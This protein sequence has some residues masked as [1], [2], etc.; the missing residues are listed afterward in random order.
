MSDR[1][2]L[3]QI[4]EAFGC[5]PEN[6]KQHALALVAAAREYLRVADGLVVRWEYRDDPVYDAAALT[7]ADLLP[8]AADQPVAA[9]SE[10]SK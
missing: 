6:V 7:L 2:T 3:E 4:A 8:R 9:Q 5:P 10:D 1:Y